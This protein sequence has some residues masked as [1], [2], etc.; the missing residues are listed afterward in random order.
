MSATA[1]AM[2]GVA[3]TPVQRRPLVMF[4]VVLAT[5]MSALDLTIGAVALPHMRG[6]FSA[7]PDQVSW[8]LTSYI[9]ATA[10]VMPLTGWLSMRFGRKRLFLTAIVGFTLASVLC[11]LASSLSQEVLFRAIQGMFGAPLVPLA[12]S[13]VL[14]THSREEQGRAMSIW[15]FGVTLA[16]IIGPV[17]GGFLTEAYGWPW[18]FYINVPLG[19]VTLI[20]AIVA[21]PADPPS[22]KTKVDGFGIAALALFI[23]CTQLVLDRGERYDWFASAEILIETGL[24]ALGLYLF[25]VHCMTAE[26]PFLERRLFRDRNYVIGLAL[27]FLFGFILLPPLFMLPIFLQDLRG[28]PLSTVGLQKS[29][30]GT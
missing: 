26:R 17:L 18:I 3:A 9:V 1:G 29:E 14:D 6:T 13:I 11:G 22:Q 10:V 23:A 4:A 8:V 16:P 25:V 19:V 15:G 5:G 24:A 12:Q 21:I 28:Y 20:A 27:V 2:G 30:R 7:T